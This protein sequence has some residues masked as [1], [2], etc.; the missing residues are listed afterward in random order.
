MVWVE[1]VQKLSHDQLV[2]AGWAWTGGLALDEADDF[3]L[4][5][6]SVRHASSPL[7]LRQLLLLLLYPLLHLLLPTTTRGDQSRRVGC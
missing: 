3:I 6:H 2:R 4:S 7:Q 5:Q 1:V